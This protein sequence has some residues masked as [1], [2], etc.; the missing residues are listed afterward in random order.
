M[1]C[2][3]DFIVVPEN[4]DTVVKQITI[5]DNKANQNKAKKHEFM[6]CRTL[7]LKIKMFF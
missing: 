6:Y 1:F 7:Y 2:S 5:R 3:L 4:D